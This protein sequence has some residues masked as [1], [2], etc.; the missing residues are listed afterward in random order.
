M[1]WTVGAIPIWIIES[2]QKILICREGASDIEV[3]GFIK[4]KDDDPRLSR[5][6]A[7]GKDYILATER[8]YVRTDKVEAW[9]LVPDRYK[10]SDKQKDGGCPIDFK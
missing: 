7:Y 9:M 3:A 6:E 1:E 8:W 5:V 2:G 4:I 10:S